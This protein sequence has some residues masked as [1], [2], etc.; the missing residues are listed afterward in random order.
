[1]VK[2]SG[3]R[4]GQRFG[5]TLGKQAGKRS[6]KGVPAPLWTRPKRPL[7]VCL[8]ARLPCVA[9]CSQ[10]AEKALKTGARGRSRGRKTGV[11]NR[12]ENRAAKIVQKVPKSRAKS[13]ENDWKK[14]MFLDGYEVLGLGLSTYY[15]SNIVQIRCNNFKHLR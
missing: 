15:S 6:G 2:R 5:Q 7:T 9:D 12:A 14:S 13:A 10:W 4:F 1:M 3:Q 11:A 8:A